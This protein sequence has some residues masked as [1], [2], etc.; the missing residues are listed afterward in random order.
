MLIGL[1]TKAR[2]IVES[3]RLKSSLAYLSVPTYWDLMTVMGLCV[4]VSW[5]M[6]SD[7]ISR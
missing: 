3:H 2:Q 5:P 7:E 1:L 6:P 4:L